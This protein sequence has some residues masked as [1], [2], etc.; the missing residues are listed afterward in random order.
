MALLLKGARLVDP[1]VGLDEVA[2]MIVRDGVIV[3]I[4]QNLSIP[5]GETRDLTGKVIIP[6]MIDMHVHFRDPGQ[7]HKEDIFSG[8]CAA[9]K[10]G[11][12]AVCPMPNT[13][14]TCDTASVVEHQINK[15]DKAG[16]CHVYPIGAITKGL[17]GVEIAEVG[18][19]TKAGAVAFSDD[20]RGVQNTGV[21]RIGMDYIKQFDKCVISHCEDEGLVGNGVVNEGVVSTRLGIA[22][23]PAAGEEIQINRDIDLARLTGCKLHIAHISTKRGVDAVRAAKAEGLPVTCEV[24]PHHLFLCEDDITTEYSVDMK[25]NPPLRTKEDMLALQ[26]ALVDGAIDC[27]VTDHAPHAQ[28]EK[29][30]EFELAPFGIIGLETALPLILTNLV[31]SGRMSYARLVEVMSHGARKVLGLPLVTLEA[32]SVADLTV[33]DPEAEWTFTREDIESKS[34]NSPFVGYSFKGRP[35]DTYLGGYATMQDGELIVPCTE[36]E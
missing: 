31:Q 22:G 13:K 28:H 4:G 7:E 24:T 20:G 9:A 21:L 27:V 1:S 32:G 19:M 34:H 29:E 25:M 5:K 23:W 33:F 12:T 17:K 6:G 18:D 11:F 30:V 2:D 8:S 16:M 14:P 26:E 3:E 36:G 10:G 15:A 35:T